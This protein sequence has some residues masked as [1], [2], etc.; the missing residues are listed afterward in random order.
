MRRPAGE[1]ASLKEKDF[2]SMFRRGLN[3]YA[4]RLQ[5]ACQHIKQLIKNDFKFQ[6]NPAAPTTGRHN[7]AVFRETTPRVSG[8]KNG[9]EEPAADAKPTPDKRRRR[10]RVSFAPDT[11]DL[12]PD[13]RSEA[14]RQWTC[15]CCDLDLELLQ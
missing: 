6:R 5:S 3:A 1:P 2:L 13:Q 4:S 11:P 10:L 12:A 15:P 9:G 14:Q 7:G 8:R